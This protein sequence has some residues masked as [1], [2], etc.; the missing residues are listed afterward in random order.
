LVAADL[1]ARWEKRLEAMEGAGEPA[2]VLPNHAAEHA[3]DD[4]HLGAAGFWNPDGRISD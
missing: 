1:V 3:F 2:S 4:A